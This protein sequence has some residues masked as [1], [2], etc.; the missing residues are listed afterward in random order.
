MSDEYSYTPPFHSLLNV[1]RKLDYSVSALANKPG[2]G[3]DDNLIF[4]PSMLNYALHTILPRNTSKW[5]LQVISATTMAVTSLHWAVAVIKVPCSTK[6]QFGSRNPPS[7]LGTHIYTPRMALIPLYTLQVQRS[8]L[9]PKSCQSI[10][11]ATVGLGVSDF[12][13]RIFA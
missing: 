8:S 6:A 10:I 13:Y 12:I 9:T 3:L 1:R 11:F 5:S 2:S 7:S 4:H